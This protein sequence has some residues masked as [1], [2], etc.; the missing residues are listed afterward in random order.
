M[1][2]GP[3]GRRG[4]P[5]S[6]SRWSVLALAF[7]TTAVVVILG[8]LAVAL[9]SS[10][11]LGQ[12]STALARVK[13]PPFA[14]SLEFAS[15]YGPSGQ[16]I[17]LTDRNG[18][19]TPKVKLA[20]GEIVTVDVV[21]RRPG[22]LSWA[23]GRVRHEQLTIR[24]PVARVAEPWL[25]RVPGTPLRVSFDRSVA[26]AATLTAG[27]S[28]AQRL[29]RGGLELHP[30]AAAGS[31]EVS[32]AA[33]SWERLGTPSYVTWFPPSS[34]PVVVA[35]PATGAALLPTAA[36]HLTFSRPVAD[37][38]G[39]AMPRLL[40]HAA[41]S[42]HE[43]DS[44][45]LVF[46]P[47]GT[48]FPLAST[49]QVEL[50][51]DVVVSQPPTG[52]TQ[53]T[54]VI[55]YAVAGGSTLRLQQLLAE[56]GYLP[57]DWNPTGG[58]VAAT[59]QAEVAA[60]VKPP[61]GTFSWR[62]SNTPSS[63]EALWRPGVSNTITKG[64]VMMFENEHRLAVDGIAGPEVWQ[65]L[66][67]AVIAGQRRTARYSYVYVHALVPESLTLWSGGHVVLRSPGNTGIPESPTQ[68][69]TFAVYEHIPVG[70][71]RGTNPDGSHYDDPGIRYISYFNG[72]DAIHEF[73]RGS[74][75]T[76]QSLGCVELPLA[77]AA[78]AWPYTPIGTLVTVES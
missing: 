32:A 69:G 36:I 31:I 67:H 47:S 14:G 16:A 70:T 64:A 38:L 4:A 60:A 8:V 50:P 54:K 61:A 63:L 37:V 45:T 33:R 72:G 2:L 41:G 52:I 46:T 43:P 1:A 15:A 59:A 6:R 65:A 5:G 51:G 55:D 56:L 44:H 12:N 48:G 73:P 18:L 78:K 68:H 26:A 10:P 30:S 35:R 27:R 74:Y 25:T 75:G 53:P 7:A 42:W 34:T 17:P 11:S 21:V 57:V 20:P 39:S 62:Y 76:P 58:P 9:W 19:L 24:A 40:P 3:L 29:T 22:W 66:L 28:V 71:M 13:L 49:V 23:L 77:A